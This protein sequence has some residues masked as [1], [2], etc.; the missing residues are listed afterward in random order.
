MPAL[1]CHIPKA[2]WVHQI[3]ERNGL[4]VPAVTHPAEKPAER[5]GA[6]EH[7][8]QKIATFQDLDDDWDGLGAAAPSHEL[9]ESAIGLAFLFSEKRVAPPH[10][11]VAGVDGSVILEWQDPD[12]TYSDVEIIAPF[13][14]EVMVIEPGRAAR[15]WTLPTERL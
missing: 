8:I 14:A 3:D 12:G 6:W 1:E 11:V 7:A 10:R 13:S 15:H 4:S 5:T 2:D 9:L